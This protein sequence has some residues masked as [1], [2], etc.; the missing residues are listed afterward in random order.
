M[1]DGKNVRFGVFDT[2]EAAAAAYRSGMQSLF[3]EFASF[4]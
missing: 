4:V 2:I 1:K 3:A